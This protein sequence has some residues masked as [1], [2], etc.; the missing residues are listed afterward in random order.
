MRPVGS[1][2]SRMAA[3][4]AE[5]AAAAVS[6]QPMVTSGAISASAASDAHGA[7]EERRGLGAGGDAGAGQHEEVRVAQRRRALVERQLHASRPPT[8]AETVRR[9]RARPG[10]RPAASTVPSDRIVAR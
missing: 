8:V 10:T 6:P 3:E 2:K 9:R 5:S 7:G 1:T 4:V